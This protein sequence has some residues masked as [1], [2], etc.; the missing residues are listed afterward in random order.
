[1]ISIFFYCLQLEGI[2]LP[3]STVIG[4]VAEIF[5]EQVSVE[6]ELDSHILTNFLTFINSAAEMLAGLEPNEDFYEAAQVCVCVC[7]CV[8]VWVGGWVGGWVWMC[9]WVCPYTECIL[10]LSVCVY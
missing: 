9:G 4:D 2:N 7:V 6:D 10:C 3:S 8:R 5:T 1:M